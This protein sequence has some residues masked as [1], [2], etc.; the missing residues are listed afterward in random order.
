[1]TTASTTLEPPRS[2]DEWLVARRL[3]EEYAASLGIDLAFQD[4][5]QEIESLPRHYGEPDG[6][7]ILATQ[8]G[9]VVG[10]GAVR[11]FSDSACEMKRLYVVPARRG[12]GVGRTIVAELIDRARALGYQS[13]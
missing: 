12:E 4:F 2:N 5:K 6:C 13:M 1:M 7:F 10:C 8:D 3:V 9:A 11:R